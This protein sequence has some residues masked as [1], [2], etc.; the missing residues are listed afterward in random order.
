MDIKGKNLEIVKN[1]LQY[2]VLNAKTEQETAEF[3][4]LLTDVQGEIYKTKKDAMVFGS[5]E[6]C[7][8]KYCDKNPK[9]EGTCRYK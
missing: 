9:C 3:A 5:L 2:A 1:A 8:F 6:N 4:L 7:P